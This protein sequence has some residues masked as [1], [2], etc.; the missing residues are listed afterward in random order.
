MSKNTVSA[1]AT[2]LPSRRLILAAAPAAAFL[3]SAHTIAAEETPLATLIERH[4]AACAAF[5]SASGLDDEVA[6]DDPRFPALSEQ[7]AVLF[8]AEMAALD[9]LCAYR[10]KTIEEARQRG[11][12]LVAWTRFYSLTAEQERALLQSYAS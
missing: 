4:K 7:R 8:D 12:Y 11:D 6:G 3:T 5:D 1:S 2:G 10:P 9:E